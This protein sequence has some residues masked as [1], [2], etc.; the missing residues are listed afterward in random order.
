MQYTA[1]AHDCLIWVSVM[2]TYCNV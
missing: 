1:Y 2:Y